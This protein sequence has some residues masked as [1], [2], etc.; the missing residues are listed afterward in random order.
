MQYLDF[1]ETTFDNMVLW[2]GQWRQTYSTAGM[3]A[4]IPRTKLVTKS[5]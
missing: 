4:P 1:V 5:G 2:S 3:T